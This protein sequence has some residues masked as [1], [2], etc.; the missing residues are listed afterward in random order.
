MQ[1][2]KNK[3]EPTSAAGDSP[4]RLHQLLERKVSRKEF[5][6][7]IMA[8]L[9]SL[10]GFDKLINLLTHHNRLSSTANQGYSSSSYGGA[11]V[12]KSHATP[13]VRRPG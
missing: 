3:A 10:T 7:I 8:G 9:V 2:N 4:F 6:G 11:R 12:S 5:I 1:E 13:P